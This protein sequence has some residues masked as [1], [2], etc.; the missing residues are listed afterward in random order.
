[1]ARAFAKFGKSLEDPETGVKI[2]DEDSMKVKHLYRNTLT[3]KKRE[4][5]EDLDYI[6]K[7]LSQARSHSLTRIGLHPCAICGSTSN[8]QMHHIRKAKDVRERIRTGD[9]TY[10]SWTGGFLRKQVP[11]CKYHHE[12]LHQGKLNHSDFMKMSK[13]NG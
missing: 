8:I 1:M 11:L 6:D 9:S 10:K 4:G 13:W 5:T 12:L 7:L 2:Y 3:N